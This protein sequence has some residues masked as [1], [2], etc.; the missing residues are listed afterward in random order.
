MTTASLTKTKKPLNA[1]MLSIAAGVL[2]LLALLFL[3]APLVSGNRVLTGND[4]FNRSSTSGQPPFDQNN[5]PNGQPGITNGFP[6]TG[7]TRQFQGFQGRQAGNRSFLSVFNLIGGR[8]RTFVN[9]IAFL[10]SMAAAI[11]MLMTRNWGRVLGIIMAIIYILFAI[12]GLLPEL[13]FRL[14]G[15]RSPVGLIISVLE[16]ILAA[17]VI[18]LSSLPGKPLPTVE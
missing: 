14:N 15:I 8:N 1:T 17:A 2:V 13:L 10:V 4:S 12:I 6:G 5:L 11:G 18:I 3:A 9:A 16:L 7:T